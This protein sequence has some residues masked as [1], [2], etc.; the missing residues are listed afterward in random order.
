MILSTNK[1]LKINTNNIN[2]KKFSFFTSKLILDSQMCIANYM[3]EKK[4]KLY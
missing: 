3:S 4:I 2:T 1:Y